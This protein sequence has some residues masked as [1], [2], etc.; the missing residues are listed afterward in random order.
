VTPALA[1]G[2]FRLDPLRRE[3]RCGGDLV[4]LGGRAFDVL[5]A[6]LE[7]DERMVT[8]D[9]LMA[10]V[11][12]GL[13]IEENN[14]QVQVSALRKALR[15][16]S[17]EQDWILTVPGR[18]YR[19]L[20]SRPSQSGDAA[21]GGLRIADR[22]SLAVLAFANLSGSLDHEYLAD[23]LSEEIIMS[24]TRHRWFFVMSRNSS[25]AYKGQPVDVKRIAEA[26]G[27]R[28]ILEGSV[29]RSAHR[30]RVSAR[31]SDGHTATAIWSETYDRELADIIGVQVDIATQVAG[32]L[33]PE[34][35][36]LESTR[37]VRAANNVGAWDLLR[38]GTWYFHQI[39]QASSLRARELFREAIKADER[40][41][42]AHMW[43]SR[44]A[45]LLSV[46]GWAPDRSALLTE[47]RSAATHAVASDERD[48]YSHYALSM[49]CMYSGEFEPA[50][51][52]ARRSLELNPSFALGHAALGQ[53]L[54]YAGRANEAIAPLESGVRLNPYDPQNFHWL[55]VLAMAYLLGNRADDA[56]AAALRALSIR[57]S[58]RLT[59]ETAALCYASLGQLDAAR[60][61]IEEMHEA[62]AVEAD[63]V[64]ILKAS[65]PEW[66]AR[67]QR[68]GRQAG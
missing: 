23:G 50:I 11:W 62:P 41:G 26:L 25:F 48:P 42:E 17:S 7:A 22:P 29:R 8:K 43:L 40:L 63:P 33:E 28:Y 55:R 66:A 61:C 32:A 38:Q 14:I 65:H 19:L 56:L 45:T 39:T 27:V 67:I 2:P 58:W 37:A 13:V 18:G 30:I 16:H 54:V 68:L 36:R 10:R 35:L 59:L 20:R 57:P 52:A 49:A 21:G 1:F 9:E 5:L 64:A 4:A 24:L 6:L 47:A 44:V 3:L 51:R 15:E 31:L 34:L 12:P 53:A 60:E 46:Y